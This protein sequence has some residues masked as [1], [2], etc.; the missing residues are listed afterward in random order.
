MQEATA[1]YRKKSKQAWVAKTDSG[2]VL[3]PLDNLC[4]LDGESLR[5]LYPNE[6]RPRPHEGDNLVYLIGGEGTI[7]SWALK[8]DAS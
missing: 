1:M 7:T 3:L 2:R 4:V 5:A 6:R 8:K